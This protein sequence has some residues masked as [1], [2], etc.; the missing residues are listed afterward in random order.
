[1]EKVK[2]EMR[3]SIKEKNNF[4]EEEL[5]RIKLYPNTNISKQ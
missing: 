5:S 3:R 1:M 4:A 2:E